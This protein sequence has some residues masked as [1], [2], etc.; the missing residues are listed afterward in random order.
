MRDSEILRQVWDTQLPLCLR[1]ARGEVATLHEPD[2]LF[3]S[4]SRLSY[5]PLLANR[6]LRQFR[7]FIPTT[8]HDGADL[9]FEFAGQ[10]L[11]AHLPVG[12]LWDLFS[13]RDAPPLPWTLTVHFADFPHEA[14]LRCNS[15]AAVETLFR[16]AVKEADALK[17]SGSV[18]ASL[19]KHETTQLWQSLALGKFD[20]FWAV[21]ERLMARL[22]DKHFRCVPFRLYTDGQRTP[23]L[24][25]AV[26]PASQSTLAELLRACS[27]DGAS[28]VTHGVRLPADASLQWLSEHMSYADNFLHLVL[29]C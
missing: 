3:V 10:P 12:V 6:L 26:R 23:P 4:M 9:W 11:K 14:L 13:A 7:P 16:S 17:H 5:L 24:Q 27:A 28:V 20:D 2:A 22:D 8:A 25:R 15:R 18:V 19:Q 29:V 21:N 1:L